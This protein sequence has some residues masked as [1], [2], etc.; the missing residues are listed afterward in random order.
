ML[1]RENARK[2]DG[3]PLSILDLVQISEG[4]DTAD[5]IGNSVELIQNAEKWGFNRY[6]LAEHH[7]MPG[8]ASSSTAVL[9][10]KLAGETKEIRVGSGGVMLPNHAPLIVA[11][12]FGTLDAMYPD[13]ID[14]GLG[15]APGTDQPTMWALR[16]NRN[17]S[18][19]DFPREVTELQAYF[20]GGEDM[21]VR[22]YPGDGQ[23]IPIWLL[24]SS[25]FSAQLSAQKGLP[26]SFASHFAPGYLIPALELYRS[27]FQPSDQLANPHAMPGANVII[28]ETQEEADHLATT[29]FQQ[30]LSIIRDERGK[31]KPPVESMDG[32]WTPT[33]KQYVFRALDPKTTIIGTPDK[34][35]EGLRSLIE[36]TQ[37]DELIINTVAYDF[38]DR[39]R[40][41]EYLA[42]MME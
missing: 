22:A 34:V 28:A 8:V 26:F 17:G 27:G 36:L 3:I 6:W 15:R 42:D 16:R 41:F 37:A 10:G 2:F 30:F 24:G 19:D 12:Q 38:K 18:A 32:I 11:E 23:D 13:R 35:R 9:I 1:I 39:L 7:N 5:A 4:H 25:G 29:H 14:L 33:E 21:R 20:K 31:V 40:S